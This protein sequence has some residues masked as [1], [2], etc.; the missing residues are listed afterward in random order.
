MCLVF[1][2]SIHTQKLINRCRITLTQRDKNTKRQ[3][4][5]ET[6]REM[7]IHTICSF[8]NSDLGS[9]DLLGVAGRAGLI[10]KGQD[11][12]D[13]NNKREKIIIIS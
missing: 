3:S 2:Q 4:D 7:H 6:K 5:I 11:I 8:L 9:A 10:P 13:K 12:W 1:T